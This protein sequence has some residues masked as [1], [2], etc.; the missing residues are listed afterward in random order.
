MR[1][2]PFG[3]GPWRRPFF[4]SQREDSTAAADLKPTRHSQYNWDMDTFVQSPAAR[5]ETTAMFDRIAFR[6]DL[7]NRMLSFRQ[8]TLWRHRMGRHLPQRPNQQVLDLATGTADVLISL[9]ADTGKVARGIGVDLSSNMLTLGRGKIARRGLDKSLSM[10]RGDASRLGFADAS[11]DAVTM[12]FGIRNVVDVPGA[13]REIR[14]V[15]RPGD[16]R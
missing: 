6:Y 3:G 8:D 4:H 5:V 16:A 14:R 12:A 11:F 9:Y 10:L 2:G 1:T 13:L 7:L 15:L